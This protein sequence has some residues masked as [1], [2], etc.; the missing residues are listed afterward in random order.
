M[1]GAHTAPVFDPSRWAEEFTAQHGRRPRVLHIGNIAA[2]AYNNAKL[3]R[4]LGYEC[5]VLCADYYHMM[6]CPEWEDADFIGD[7]RDHFAPDWTTVD[8]KCFSRPQW[9]V[10]GPLDLC[11]D[12]LI[13]RAHGDSGSADAL[14]RRLGVLNKTRRA[15]ALEG[16][17]RRWFVVREILR[18]TAQVLRSP[19]RRARALEHVAAMAQRW[20]TGSAAGPEGGSRCRRLVRALA[21]WCIG[22]CVPIMR[23]LLVPHRATPT[24]ER[25]DLRADGDA[26]LVAGELCAD[27]ARRFPGRPDLLTTED[28]LAYTP[29]LKKWRRALETY[30]VIQGYATDAIHPM[31]ARRDYCAFEHGTLRELP[32]RPDAQG[33]MTALAYARASHVFVTNSDCMENARKLAAGRASALPHPFDEDRALRVSGADELRAIL[34]RELHATILAFFPTRHDWVKGTGFADK[35]NDRFFRAIAV[36]RA[37]GVRVGV[38]CCEWGRNVAESRILLRDLGLEDSVKWVAPMGVVRYERHVLACDIVVDQFL[39]GAFG[40]VTFRALAAGRPVLTWLRV[41]EVAASF[42]SCPPILNCRTEDEIAIALREALARP[43]ELERIGRDARRWVEQRHSGYATARAQLK[44]YARIVESNAT[45]TPPPASE[46]EI[47]CA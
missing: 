6:G 36:L 5:D 35:A 43:G 14:W 45:G 40:G 46:G 18:R 24:P 34:Q 17:W 20:R 28:V 11:L 26:L 23:V 16:V 33:R 29:V 38:I 21:G 27:F 15:G 9:F 8:L 30:D 44:E 13:A 10:Q 42:G 32:F 12:Y 2:N 3:M 41:E 7:I 4:A 47:R 22:A 31:L 25:H 19:I 37:E 1:G 39:L